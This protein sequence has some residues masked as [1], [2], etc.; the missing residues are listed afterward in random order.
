[1]PRPQFS[2]KML[3]WLMVVVAAF[4]GGSSWK[5]RL[6]SQQ[7]SELEAEKR[8]VESDLA[9]RQMLD[10]DM[11]IGFTPYRGFYMDEE[12]WS[13]VQHASGKAGLDTS[14]G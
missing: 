12:S 14:F 4:L 2:L 1:M 5:H 11:D 9:I 8:L 6:L 3:L 13:L 7:I 10:H